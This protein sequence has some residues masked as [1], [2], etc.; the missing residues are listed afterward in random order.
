M[1][2]YIVDGVDV[3]LGHPGA[4]LEDDVDGRRERQVTP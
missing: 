1:L 3:L 4:F 2:D